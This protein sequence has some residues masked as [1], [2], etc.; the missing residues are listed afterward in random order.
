MHKHNKQNPWLILA[1]TVTAVLAIVFALIHY[2][3]PN[4]AIDS[5]QINVKVGNEEIVSIDYNEGDTLFNLIDQNFE[6]KYDIYSFSPGVESHFITQIGSLVPA[7]SFFIS[8]RVDGVDSLKGIDEIL[9]VDG[10]LVTFV[11]VEFN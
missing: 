7:P 2:Q 9:I 10:M 4:N 11:L 6:I 3:T 1:I 5:G 8:I